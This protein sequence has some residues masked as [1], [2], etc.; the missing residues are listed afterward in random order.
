MP[1]I[2]VVI[3]TY[4]RDRF[5]TPAFESLLKQDF[6]DFEVILV[7]NNSPDQTANITKSFMASY[8]GFPLRYV[9]ET[10]QGHSHARNRG[11]HEAKADIISFI[12]DDVILESDFLKELKAYFDSNPSIHAAG[13]RILPLFEAGRPKWL[14][15]W[16]EPLF[17]CVDLG[18]SNTAFKGRAYPFGANMAFRADV[19]K[20]IGLFN[21]ELGRKGVSL[22]GAD[23]KDVFLRLKTRGE[24][25]GYMHQVVLH[26]VMPKERGEMSYIRRQAIAV[27]ISER[28]RIGKTAGG[29]FGKI[30]SELIK[31]AGSVVLGLGYLIIGRPTAGWMLLKF[32]FWVQAGLFGGKEHS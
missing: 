14:S 11:I 30:I 7:D 19:F 12:D 26:H 13:G 27:G 32:R 8:P 29:W 28:I 9:L 31:T 18:P 17:A 21:P 15:K 3:C 20:Q 24:K 25:I 10:K 16:L 22:V 4:N 23:E 2:S 5:L 6:K 1:A